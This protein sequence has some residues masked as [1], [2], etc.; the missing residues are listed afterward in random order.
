MASLF[1]WITRDLHTVY[2]TKD[3][4]VLVNSI[5]F[6]FFNSFFYYIK[7]NEDFIKARHFQL[8]NLFFLLYTERY[9][10]TPAHMYTIVHLL[11]RKVLLVCGTSSFLNSVWQRFRHL[12]LINVCGVLGGGGVFVCLWRAGTILCN[13]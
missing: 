5:R 3:Y 10:W 6:L 9:A 12:H 8:S 11:F 13:F 7:D 2:I 1:K 4:I